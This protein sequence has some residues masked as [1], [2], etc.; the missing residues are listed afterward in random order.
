MTV[1]DRPETLE[2]EIARFNS[3][4]V[5]AI[6]DK[7]KEVYGV[8]DAQALIDSYQASLARSGEE[9][10]ASGLSGDA[11]AE[12]MKSEIFDKLSETEYGL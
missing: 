7:A 2:A 8:T 5:S 12:R 6:V 11:L 3:E 10:T 1:M 4:D 9:I